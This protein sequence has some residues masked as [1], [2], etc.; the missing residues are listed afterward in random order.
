MDEKGNEREKERERERGRLKTKPR[1]LIGR[2]IT[3]G[4]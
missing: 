4:T 2:S 1:K 3:L